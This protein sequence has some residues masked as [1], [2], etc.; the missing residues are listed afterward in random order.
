MKG[1]PTW[2]PVSTNKRF[3]LLPPSPKNFARFCGGTSNF[4]D[5]GQLSLLCFLKIKYNSSKNQY[6]KIKILWMSIKFIQQTCDRINITGLKLNCMTKHQLEHYSKQHNR[7]IICFQY[8][9]Y[10]LP[11]S[12]KSSIHNVNDFWLSICCLL[13]SFHDHFQWKSRNF[14]ISLE[15]CDPF[16][17]TS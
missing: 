6:P 13:Y 4:S 14:D 1:P 9:T 17:C 7:Q 8:S 16:L 11:C 10:F 2:T 15:S 12:A 3:T 5:T